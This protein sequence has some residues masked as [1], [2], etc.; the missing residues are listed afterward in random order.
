LPN[1]DAL[2]GGRRPAPTIWPELRKLVIERRGRLDGLA[3]ELER[4]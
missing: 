3:R 4:L 1:F 2:G